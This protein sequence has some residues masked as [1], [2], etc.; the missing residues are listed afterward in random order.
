MKHRN[1]VLVGLILCLILVISIGLWKLVPES[2]SDSIISGKA[3][4]RE[5]SERTVKIG[6]LPILASLPLYVA[7][8]NG[9]FDEQ[10]IRVEPVILQSSNQLVD[11]LVRGDIDIV[12]ESSA[13]PVLI[14]ETIDPGKIKVFSASDITPET[15]FDSL[16][17]PKGSQLSS[18]YD[19]EGKK[20]G[21]FP[22]STA[23]NL[24]KSFLK[25]KGVDVTEIEFIQIVPPTQLPAL[26]AGTIDV[27]H[28]YEP[29]TTIALESGNAKKLYGS[30]YA[31]Q[32]NHNPQGVALISSKFIA[33]NPTLANKV[34]TSFDKASDFIEQNEGKARLII[35]KYVKLDQNVADKS[36]LLYMSRSDNINK[37]AM[38]KYVDML[39]DVG[40]LKTRVSTSA[41][42]YVP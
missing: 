32:L 18:L 38:K 1:A 23:T 19:L 37:V 31:E 29:T 7:Q 34:V 10:G 13:V 3:T 11:A 5:Y 4:H 30:V 17:I 9:Y 24:L 39:Y 21:V 15:P 35:P 33:E 8:E 25:D 27:L 22:G 20:I 40:E 26:Y 6:Y 36:V 41:L 2:T 12:V 28:S 16:I 42:Y 14:V